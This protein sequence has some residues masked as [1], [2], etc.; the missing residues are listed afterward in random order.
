MGLLAGTVRR[1]FRLYPLNE[2]RLSTVAG[3]RA[4]FLSNFRWEFWELLYRR[5]DSI[6]RRL[7]Q[8]AKTAP[9]ANSDSVEGSG[10][11]DGSNVYCT[12]ASSEDP[13]R[14]SDPSTVPPP[15]RWRVPVAPSD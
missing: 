15:I 9:A 4:R 6:A 10:V 2:D 11:G 3:K 12:A 14:D 5:W 13:T 8:A 7:R 1:A